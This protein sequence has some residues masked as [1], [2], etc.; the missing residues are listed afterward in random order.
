MGIQWLKSNQ[1][2]LGGESIILNLRACLG[3]ALGLA[4]G[5]F[6]DAP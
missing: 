6:L 4:S 5:R 2:L 3:Q 1:Y